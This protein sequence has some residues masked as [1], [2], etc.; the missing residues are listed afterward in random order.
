[1]SRFTEKQVE[2]LDKYYKHPRN[3]VDLF[4][5]TATK[6]SDRNAIGTKNLTTKQYEWITYKLLAERINNARGGIH[7][8]GINKGDAVGVIIGNSVEWYVLENAAHGLGAIFVP[9]Y[10]KELKKTWQYII[11]D[12]GLKYLFVKD[13]KIFEEVQHFKNEIETLKEIFIIYGEGKNSLRSLEEAGKKLRE[14]LLHF[15]SRG[16]MN[17]EGLGEAVV[18]QLLDRGLVHSVADLYSLTEEQLIDASTDLRKNPP[19]RSSKR[20]I[21]PKQPDWRAC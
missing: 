3:L 12:S 5:D 11:K 19:A 21:A 20:L 1:M 6:W 17:I 18:Q 16:V 10:E 4:E 13:E 8:L 14:S 2:E 9:M 7:Q 15:A